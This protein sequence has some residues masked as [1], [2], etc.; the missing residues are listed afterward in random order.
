M[1]AARSPSVGPLVAPCS[2][3]PLS[4]GPRLSVEFQRVREIR[5]MVLVMG[6]WAEGP[7]D[8]DD[9]ADFCGDLQDSSNPDAAGSDLDRALAVGSV[10]GY[11]ETSDM[12]A[13]IAAAAI[14][15]VLAGAAVPASS[16]APT[17]EWLAL[18]RPLAI[19]TRRA[20]AARVF[21]RAFEPDENEWFELWHEASAIDDVHR[22]LA[23]FMSALSA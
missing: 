17:A 9:A 20:A 12:N 18:M 8:N 19:P 10:D 3:V 5:G 16:Y 15:A 1:S 23:S 14:V 7:F 13:G 2:V 11:I 4:L 21:D 6:A 22:A